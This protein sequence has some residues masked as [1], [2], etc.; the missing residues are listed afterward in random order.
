M[1]R[2]I[3]YQKLNSSFFFIGIALCFALQLINSVVTEFN[4]SVLII[5]LAVVTICFY[6]FNNGLIALIR[7]RFGKPRKND[8]HF[9][10]YDAVKYKD[11]I[12]AEIGD[13][14]MVYKLNS[15]DA[16]QII[17]QKERLLVRKCFISDDINECIYE[18]DLSNPD[19]IKFAKGDISIRYESIDKITYK[20]SPTNYYTA[21]IEIK[22]GKKTYRYIGLLE[23]LV[24]DETK[25]F[26][27]SF[28]KVKTNKEQIDKVDEKLKIEKNMFLFRIL[29]LVSCVTVPNV[30][31]SAMVETKGVE[32]VL[33]SVYMLISVFALILYV[34][35]P[36]INPKKFGFE[37]ERGSIGK[38]SDTLLAMMLVNL[39]MFITIVARQSIIN[40]SWYIILVGVLTVILAYL[41]LKVAKFYDLNDEKF[42]KALTIL[43]A[44]LIV[45]MTSASIV[46]G[47]NYTI[48]LKSYSQTYTIEEKWEEHTSKGGTR[49][50]ADVRLDGK[51]ETVLISSD[52]FDNNSNRIQLVRTRGILGI[53]YITEDLSE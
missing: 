46:S 7:G 5:S 33:T 25:K 16:F 6:R 21:I 31:I 44:V 39:A 43:T 17:K 11:E 26:F 47:I 28:C 27:E 42:T 41:Y 9:V 1:K 48:P 40:L 38:K 2:K 8:V 20:I 36:I 50:Y 14:L 34:V 13:S 15:R 22:V 30:L 49:Y 53:E 35:L 24:F 52:T 4:D 18:T 12:K 32:H 45:G 37:V 10:D 19:S 29:N 51:D 23:E 3:N